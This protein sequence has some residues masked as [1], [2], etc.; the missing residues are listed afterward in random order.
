MKLQALQKN[1]TVRPTA[2]QLLEHPWVRGH[3]KD[4]GIAS[5]QNEIDV[6]AAVRELR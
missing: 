1:P 4:R 6:P 5:L 2:A 3:A